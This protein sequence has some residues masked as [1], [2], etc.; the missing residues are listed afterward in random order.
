MAVVNP[1]LNFD[2][3]CEEAFEFYKSVFGGDYMG[4]IMRMGD[5]GAC[6]GLSEEEKSMVMHV[7]LP[8]SDGN[9]LMGS[10]CPSSMGPVKFGTSNT[11]A[12]GSDSKEETEKLFNGL[13]EGGKV[14]MPLEKMF[15]GGYFG[16][17]EDKFGQQW[18]INYQADPPP[19]AG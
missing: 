10:D 18:L 13:S 19:H 8:I 7:A 6:E 12:I 14:I 16:N 1:Y 11:I 3:K 15:W 5:T 4:G 9:V 17:W 2:G